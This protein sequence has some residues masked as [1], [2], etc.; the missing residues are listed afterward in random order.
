MNINPCFA[1][2]HK[3][4]LLVDYLA[5]IYPADKPKFMRMKIGQLRAMIY[6][7]DRRKK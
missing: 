5:S 2:L 1:L 6:N 7:I 3:K 4:F